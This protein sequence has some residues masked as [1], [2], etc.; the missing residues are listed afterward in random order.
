MLK[1]L[2]PLSFWAKQNDIFDLRQEGSGK[3]FLEDSVFV[4]WRDATL[5]NGNNTLLCLGI[6][7]F[8]QRFHLFALLWNVC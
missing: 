8:L 4:N 5:N 6:R 7:K 3:W 1:W 2:S